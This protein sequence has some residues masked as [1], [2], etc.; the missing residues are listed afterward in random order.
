MHLRLTKPLISIADHR[1]GAGTVFSSSSPGATRKQRAKR[2]QHAPPPTTHSSVGRHPRP[3]LACQHRAA[4]NQ[5]RQDCPLGPHIYPSSPRAANPSDQGDYRNDC[6]GPRSPGSC[7]AAPVPAPA[8]CPSANTS[9]TQFRAHLS[10]ATVR[11]NSLLR[12]TPHLSRNISARASQANQLRK[13]GNPASIVASGDVGH[14]RP[15]LFSRR[16]RRSGGLFPSS[17]LRIHDIC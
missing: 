5:T 13:A 3:S 14:W 11:L 1:S 7:S 10:T 8:T 12:G 17:D 9:A 16:H 6:S 2:P 4:T 15:P